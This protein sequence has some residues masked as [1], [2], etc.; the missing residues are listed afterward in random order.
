MGELNGL[1]GEA[2]VWSVS[3]R[4][5]GRVGQAVKLRRRWVCSVSL[6]PC[7]LS[8]VEGGRP[9]DAEPRASRALLLPQAGFQPSSWKSWMSGARR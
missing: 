2:S 4:A 9:Q 7:V 6:S 1:R 8:P 5:G 3:C